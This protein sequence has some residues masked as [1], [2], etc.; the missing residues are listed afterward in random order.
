V[1][2]IAYI[3]PGACVGSA[4]T[5][6]PFY[7]ASEHGGVPDRCSHGILNISSFTGGVCSVDCGEVCFDKPS[8]G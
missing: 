1:G 4:L 3:C 7:E 8:T 5:R 2:W 6:P